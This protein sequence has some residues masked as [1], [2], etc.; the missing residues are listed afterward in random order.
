MTRRVLFT[1][2]CTAIV[3]IAFTVPALSNPAGGTANGGSH[4]SIYNLSVRGP[5]Q[6]V[7]RNM[8]ESDWG[9][10]HFVGYPC[11]WS[12]SR[13]LAHGETAY[14]SGRYADAITQWKTAASKDCAIAAY[15]LGMLYYGGKSQVAADRSLGTA[16]LKVAAES[17]T[18]SSPNYM[19]MSQLAVG[20]L[21]KSQRA[22]YTS[23]YARLRTSLGLPAAG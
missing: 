14:R 8:S 12:G 16:W 19:K 21:T 13:A 15:K 17:G 18:A 23:D 20:T 6:V 7:S 10:R 11:T 1:S 3:G 2:L 9:S 5:G 4:P 22:E